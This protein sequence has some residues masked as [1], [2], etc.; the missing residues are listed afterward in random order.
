MKKNTI[1]IIVRVTTA[2]NWNTDRHSE[3][4]RPAE[5]MNPPVAAPTG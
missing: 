1:G 3:S 2:P 5:V 4:S